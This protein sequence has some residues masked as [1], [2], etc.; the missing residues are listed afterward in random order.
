M[1]EL[2][3]DENM[4]DDSLDYLAKILNKKNII[5]AIIFFI[6]LILFLRIPPF[7]FNIYFIF[8]IGIVVI[9]LFKG[10][11]VLS[12][13]QVKNLNNNKQHLLTVKRKFY[14]SIL[15]IF[16]YLTAKKAFESEW[17]SENIDTATYL[18]FGYI[19]FIILYK[20]KP[21]FTAVLCIFLIIFMAL[22]SLLNIE[23]LTEN[24]TILVYLFFSAAVI[25]QV[26]LLIRERSY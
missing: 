15:F 17:F 19:P 14:L 6:S 3:I 13:I 22:Y 25:Q 16:V 4:Q 24:F 7:E 1:L 2:L 18:F 21:N 9:L 12:K 20:L 10:F 5:H 11:S 23:V 8:L 26:V